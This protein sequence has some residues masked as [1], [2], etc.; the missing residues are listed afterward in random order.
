MKKSPYTSEQ[1]IHLSQTVISACNSIDYINYSANFISPRYICIDFL[2][3]ILQ[4]LSAC[5]TY[6]WR[7]VCNRIFLNLTFIFLILLSFLC[8]SQNNRWLIVKSRPL[9]G[10]SISDSRCCVLSNFSTYNM[11]VRKAAIKTNPRSRLVLLFL[12]FERV[13]TL[14]KQ[15][16]QTVCR[17]QTQTGL[18]PRVY[19][20][21]PQV[22]VLPGSDAG[23]DVV[24]PASS[25]VSKPSDLV[26]HVVP[27][28]KFEFCTKGMLIYISSTDKK[29][30]NFFSAHKN[31]ITQLLERSRS[32]LC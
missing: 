31:S 28:G 21:L 17:L 20:L 15:T 30:K 8:S 1:Q 7:S 16:G 19:P 11:S 22:A 3:N 14:D 12:S 13:F 9:L 25:F 6:H 24:K 10:E 4:S 5:G 18:G 26:L 29:S 27:H 23:S 2:K 32:S